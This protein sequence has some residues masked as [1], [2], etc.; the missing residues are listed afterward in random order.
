MVTAA[1]REKWDSLHAAGRKAVDTLDAYESQLR[2]KYG[3]VERSWLT[4]TELARIERLR[5]RV[6]I[7]DRRVIDLLTKISPRGDSWLQGVPSWWLARSLTW[8]DAIRPKN[9]PLS[10]VVPGSYG[11]PDGYVKERRK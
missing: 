5:A 1:D 11:Y 2:R 4:P 8:E 3:R 9:E 10:V 6:R 7:A